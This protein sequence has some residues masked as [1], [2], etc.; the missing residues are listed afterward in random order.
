VK[1]EY[2]ITTKKVGESQ[3]ARVDARSSQFLGETLIQIK[4]ND[5]TIENSQK[6]VFVENNTYL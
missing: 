4:L 1:N 6:L 2:D 5:L 3:I